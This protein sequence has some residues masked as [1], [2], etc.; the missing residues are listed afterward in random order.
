MHG[1]TKTFSWGVYNNHYTLNWRPSARLPSG[2]SECPSGIGA[3]QCWTDPD[4]GVL[5]AYGVG[6]EDCHSTCSLA[7]ATPADLMCD[8]DSPITGG[9]DEVS[10][11]MSNFENTYNTNDAGE[12]TCTTGAC[13]SGVSSTQIRI[14]EY[15]SNCYVPSNSDK[16]SCDT[17]FGNANCFGQ[18]FN[19]V[20][21]CKAGCSWAAGPSCVCITF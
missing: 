12:F 20:C 3:V 10:R 15:N 2:G 1:G 8:E 4:T 14:H 19:Q 16:Y 5:W 9:F 17:K 21:P 11:I 6:G 13:G 18:R 7:G